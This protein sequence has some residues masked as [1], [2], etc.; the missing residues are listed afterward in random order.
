LALCK[1]EQAV[2]QQTRLEL[3]ARSGSATEADRRK[4]REAWDQGVSWWKQYL[5]NHADGPA[6]PA[7]R[8]LLGEAQLGQG[9]REKAAATW[10]DTTGITNDLEQLAV[11][12][13]AAQAKQ[14]K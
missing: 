10:N 12:W 14:A 1:H 4:A 6:A 9:E 3:A 5:E 11:L 7:A 8:R 13:L 2:R